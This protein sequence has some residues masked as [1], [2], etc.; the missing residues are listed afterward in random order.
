MENVEKEFSLVWGDVAMCDSPEE[1]D[2]L[3]K[4]LHIR[5]QMIEIDDLKHQNQHL[6]NL[7]E[8]QQNHNS[9][10]SSRLIMIAQFL[11]TFFVGK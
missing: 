3:S 6:K 5:K 7:T 10:Q 4:E 9:R 11:K 8:R 1:A 2:F